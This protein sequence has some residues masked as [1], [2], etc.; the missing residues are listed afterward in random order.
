ITPAL[1]IGAFAERIKFSAMLLFMGLWL[2]FIYAPIAHMVWGGG[3]LQG[4]GVLDFAGGTVVHINA[5]IAGLV[6]ALII[7]KRAGYGKEPM[8]PHNLPLM[9]VGAALLWV[10]WFGFNVGSELAVDGTAGQV[11]ANTQ[12]ATATAALVWMF[13]EWLTRGKP[14]VL[15][16]ASGAITGLVA[17]TPAC[18]TAGPMGAIALGAVA[19]LGCY[20]AVVSLKRTIGYDDSLDVFGVHCVGGIIGALGT[21]ICASAA[22]GGVGYAEGVT[23]LG[24]F[25]KQS[26]AVLTTLAWSGII[27]FGLFKLVDMTVGLR[28]SEEQEMEGLDIAVHGESAYNIMASGS[29]R[30]YQTPESESVSASAKSAPATA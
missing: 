20:W 8:I 5:G 6:A 18:G 9:L 21:G 14:S 29:L 3:W 30:I 2:T 22:L 10:G 1:I 4:M 25:T 19:A 15:G 13:A 17:I 26:V 24:Q 7:G 16:I 28:A 12:L 11:F 27:S 23:M